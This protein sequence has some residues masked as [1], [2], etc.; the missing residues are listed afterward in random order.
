MNYFT[1]YEVFTL[2]LVSLYISVKLG[3]FKSFLFVYIVINTESVI[4]FCLRRIEY[5]VA[6]VLFQFGDQNLTA[7]SSHPKRDN[8]WDSRQSK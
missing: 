4:Y 6:I 8:F 7:F 5:S 3:I 1:I 2:Y